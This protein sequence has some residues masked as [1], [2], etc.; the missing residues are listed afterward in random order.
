MTIG[1]VQTVVVVGYLILIQATGAIAGF[2]LPAIAPE[3]GLGLGVD[4]I[5]IGYQVLIQYI[6]AMLA[7]LM[8]GGFVRRLGAWRASQLALALFAASHALFLTGSITMIVLGSVLLGCGYGLVT[9]AA[10]HL[11]NK[12]VTPRNR[13]LVFSIRFTGVPLGGITAGLAAPATALYLGWQQ[14]VLV[15]GAQWLHCQHQQQ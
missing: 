10:S 7:S 8:A 3:V 12:I 6:F 11:L 9:P 5:L 15:V 14:S 4:P 2:W 1:R 13:N